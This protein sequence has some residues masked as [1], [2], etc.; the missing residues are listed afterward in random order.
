MTSVEQDIE[1]FVRG[2]PEPRCHTFQQFV[3]FHGREFKPHPDPRRYFR[4]YGAGG[5][6]YRNALKLV[7]RFPQELTY[8]EGYASSPVIDIIQTS[9]GIHAWAVTW[10]GEVVDPTWPDGVE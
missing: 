2:Y 6:C 7:K 3:Y 8:V 5:Q 9:F 1:T 4:K 10:D